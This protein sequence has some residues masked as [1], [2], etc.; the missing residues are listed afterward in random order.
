MVPF[1][2]SA[3]AGPWED[4]VKLPG[5]SDG[6]RSA[7]AWNEENSGA[8]MGLPG[9][10]PGSPDSNPVLVLEG[11]RERRRVRHARGPCKGLA[12]SA[13]ACCTPQAGRSS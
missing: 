12:S 2:A 5:K 4:A 10:G 3:T 11:H 8:A 7:V 6:Q 9:Q 13:G 1:L